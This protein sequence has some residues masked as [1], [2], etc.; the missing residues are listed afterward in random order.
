MKVKHLLLGYGIFAIL[1]F[2]YTGYTLQQGFP[3]LYD[4]DIIIRYQYRAN[5]V[6]LLFSGLL[7][8]LYASTYRKSNSP[9]VNRLNIII[10]FII[11]LAHILLIAAFYIEPLQ[12]SENR[13]L[14]FYGIVCNIV[15]VVLAV[16]TSLSQQESGW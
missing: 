3:H 8:L 6:Y 15:A 16:F 5:H 12:A 10:M 13:P 9:Y 2:L 7:I 14:S 1:L 4:N 11:I